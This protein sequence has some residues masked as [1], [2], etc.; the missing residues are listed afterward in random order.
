MA[1]LASGLDING[2]VLSYFEGTVNVPLYKP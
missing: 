1:F 2:Y